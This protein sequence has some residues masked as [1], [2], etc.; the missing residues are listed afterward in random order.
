LLSLD[1]NVVVYTEPKFEEK[2]WSLRPKFL[3][4]RTV[5]IVQNFDDFPMSKYWDVVR[6]ARMNGRC[7][8]DL[9]NTASYYLF[10]VARFAMLRQTIEKNP[11]GSDRFAWANICIERMGFQNLVCMKEALAVQREKFSTAYIDYVPQNAF[12]SLENFFGK[13]G[14]RDPNGP[15]GR[16]SMCSGFFTA[17]ARYGIEVANLI[18]KKFLECAEQ[19]YGHADEQLIALVHHDRSDLFDWYPADYGEMVTNYAT[20]HEWAETPI[21]N[22]IRHALE[23]GAV[24]VA[25]TAAEKIWTSYLAGHCNLND[26]D[27]SILLAAKR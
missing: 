25:R 20:T 3:H 13:D 17:S 26:T 10:C 12:A 4:D 24:E 9:R 2:I 5:V 18:E 11:F 7:A 1:E 19:G 14:C 15:C 16:C 21:R 22:L 8:R 27:L 23:D 6:L